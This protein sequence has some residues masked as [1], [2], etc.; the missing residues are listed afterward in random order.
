MAPDKVFNRLA[1]IRFETA[2]RLAKIEELA[3][4]NRQADLERD[5]L[6]GPALRLLDQ[7]PDRVVLTHAWDGR[8][9]VP[10]AVFETDGMLCVTPTIEAWQV[11]DTAGSS[12]DGIHLPGRNGYHGVTPLLSDRDLGDIGGIN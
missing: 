4:Q 10:H 11:K 12:I 6:A 7:H 9:L 8:G 5:T 1:Q 2:A 3:E